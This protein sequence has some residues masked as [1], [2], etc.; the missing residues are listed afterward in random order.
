MFPPLFDVK[1]HTRVEQNYSDSGGFE[2][3]QHCAALCRGASRMHLGKV[4]AGGGERDTCSS[5]E[6]E[7]MAH[8]APAPRGENLSAEPQLRS[9]C[10]SEGEQAVGG[11]GRGEG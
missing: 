5:C 4:Q 10:Q 3:R 6:P 11:G 7:Q 8:M 2:R 1:T 9:H